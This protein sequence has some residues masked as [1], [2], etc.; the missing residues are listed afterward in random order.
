MMKLCEPKVKLLLKKV[1]KP[2]FSDDEPIKVNPNFA[3]NA[4]RLNLVPQRP[5]KRKEA[6]PTEEEK[7]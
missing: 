2:V 7:A 3:Q 4:I 1:N 5:T 6:E